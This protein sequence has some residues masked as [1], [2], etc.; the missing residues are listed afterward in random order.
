MKYKYFLLVFSGFL[1]SVPGMAQIHNPFVQSV[2]P[3]YTSKTSGMSTLMKGAVEDISKRTL[4]SSTYRTPKGKVICRY[5][6]QLLNYPDVNGILQPINTELSSDGRGWVASHQP[7]ACYFRLDRST[8]ISI[9]NGEEID[10]N[11]N[12]SIN[13]AAYDGNISSVEKNMVTLNLA[14]GIQKKINFL[15][16]SIETDYVLDSSIG[17]EVT[18]SEQIKYPSGF[19]LIPDTMR[20]TQTP[21]G[22][23]G[24]YIVVSLKDNSE[25]SRFHAPL[26]YDSK[27]NWCIGGYRTQVQNG[28]V[29][30]ITSV[31]L[32]WLAN[33]TYPIVIDPLVT[34]PTAKWTGGS[35]PSCLFPNFSKDSIHVIIPGKI[36]ITKLIINY[37][38]E[39]NG[40]VPVYL[41][42]GKFYFSTSCRN[43]PSD[44]L[45]C[46]HDKGNR[47]FEPGYC[48]LDTGADF[49]CLLTSCFAPSC[50]SQSFYLTAHLSRVTGA[51]GCDTNFVWYSK[52]LQ[53]PYYQFM[54]TVIGNTVQP[55]STA[56]LITTPTTQ[57]SDICSLKM[58]VNVNYGVPPYRISHPWDTAKY[59]GG[60]YS[61]SDNCT[62]FGSTTLNLTIPNCPTYCGKSTT[63][64]VPPP[65][66]IDACNDTAKGWPV[67]TVTINPTPKVASSPD[68][69]RVCSGVPLVYTLTSCVS[70]SSINWTGNNGVS[71]K[72]NINDIVI[73]TSFTKPDTVIYKIVSSIDGCASDTQVAVGIVNPYPAGG[74]SG[75]DTISYGSSTTLTA[76]GGSSYL[77]FPSAGLSCTT[78]PA[79]VASPTVTTIYYATVTNK[80]GCSWVDSVLVLVLD[81]KIIVPNVITP[82]GDGV[83]D[84]LVIKGLQYYPNSSLD[85]FDRWGKEIYS[86]TNYVNNWD[87]GDQSDGVY[88]YVLTLNTGEKYQGYIQ[89]IK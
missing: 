12:S 19:K 61:I 39:T 74:I 48:F 55:D 63:L 71:G 2:T 59:T 87:G 40:S 29:I 22:W 37:A 57:C 25:V 62:A 66:V 67:Q 64:T 60:L 20:G 80:E 13:G 33:A 31:P 43:T 73:D 42:Q 51:G 53:E 21:E 85:I 78:C 28:K 46:D 65:L 45:S 18:I 86:T 81:N 26:C 83:N 69:T 76:S 7:N 68:T 11:M 36:N 52:Y 16:N 27:G 15:L 77:W 24:D 3:Q 10:F 82:N 47:D 17:T 4:Y 54:A 34:G 75:V 84:Y 14:D 9:G 70:G 88:F 56:P 30:L 35:I 44:T 38:Y 49:H 6:S 8:A 79:P 1:C 89:L 58:V 5:S 50:D 72:G 41:E 32:N 23:A